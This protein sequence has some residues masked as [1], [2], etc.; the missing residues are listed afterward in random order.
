MNI[1]PQE[2]LDG[3]SVYLAQMNNL[4]A[5]WSPD[6]KA[7]ISRSLSPFKYILM[8][9]DCTDRWCCWNEHLC[10]ESMF[11]NLELLCSNTHILSIVVHRKFFDFAD[12][13]FLYTIEPWPWP[14]SPSATTYIIWV[15]HRWIENLTGTQQ[16]DRSS[17]LPH[18]IYESIT[19]WPQFQI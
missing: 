2:C 10:E 14:S 4:V 19:L 7:K 3:N 12:A 17:S 1:I 6:S 8:Y 13:G 18:K 16:Q 11:K 5:H 15:P 9:F